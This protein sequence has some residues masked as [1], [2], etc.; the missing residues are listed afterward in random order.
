MRD[1]QSR[2][3]AAIVLVLQGV[4]LLGQ[5]LCVLYQLHMEFDPLEGMAAPAPPTDT[6]ASS[7]MAV[8][9]TSQHEHTTPHGENHSRACSVVACGSALTAATP[10]HSPRFMGRLSNAQAA[11]LD[12]K[13]PFESEVVVPPPRLG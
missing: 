10:D 3:F 12:G 9:M 7:S 1:T 2:R 6:Y 13:M 11:Y 4:A 5:P 8:Q